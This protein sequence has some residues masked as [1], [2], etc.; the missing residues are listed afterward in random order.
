MYQLLF[1]RP[2]PKCFACV[3][4]FSRHMNSMNKCYY[5]VH[6]VVEEAGTTKELST[7]LRISGLD[8]AELGLG[9]TA[10]CPRICQ[11]SHFWAF[12][13]HFL[14][15]PPDNR[16]FMNVF[17]SCRFDGW[18]KLVFC[19][20]PQSQR[21]KIVNFVNIKLHFH[22]QSSRRTWTTLLSLKWNL[23]NKTREANCMSYVTV[24]PG[25]RFPRC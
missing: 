21:C 17:S 15:M 19:R 7:L 12:T 11:V 25:V 24:I 10:S 2:C 8:V 22:F 1:A 20:F 14:L 4:A 6:S 13:E 16:G 23:K 9:K 3:V 5:W 18:F